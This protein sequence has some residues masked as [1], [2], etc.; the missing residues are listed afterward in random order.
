M[1]DELDAVAAAPEHHRVLL[2]DDRIRVLETIIRPGEETRPHTHAWGGYLYIV[3]W[4]DFVRYDG[5]GN[6]ML[7]SKAKGI[8]REPGTAMW[9]PPLALHSLRNTGDQIF[10]VILTEFKSPDWKAGEGS[11]LPAQ[12]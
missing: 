12:S 10:H 11:V 2:E 7:D 6:V 5:E 3:A 1:L 4:S 9:A 8:S